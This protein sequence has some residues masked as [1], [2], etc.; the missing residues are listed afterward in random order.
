VQNS[1]ICI[2][3][4]GSHERSKFYLAPKNHSLLY[5]SIA[6]TKITNHNLVWDD[7]EQLYA[8]IFFSQQLEIYAF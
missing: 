6:Y 3:N 5:T 2:Y 4:L 7:F 1:I 8:L